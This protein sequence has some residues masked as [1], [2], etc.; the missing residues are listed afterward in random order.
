M[1]P[2]QLAR[3]TANWLAAPANRIS[4]IAQ[5]PS[6]ADWR[7]PIRPTIAPAPAMVSS[8]SI[9]IEPR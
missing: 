9:P 7:T 3:L 5:V 1:A 2:I 6:P 4:R 8:H